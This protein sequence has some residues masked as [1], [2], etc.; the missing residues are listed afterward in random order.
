MVLS[1]THD[2]KDASVMAVVEAN[3]PDTPRRLRMLHVPFLRYRDG[4]LESHSLILTLKKR[5]TKVSMLFFC[6]M[7]II[8]TWPAVAC[9]FNALTSTAD[10]DSLVMFMSAEYKL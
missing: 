3:A 9:E 10:K 2:I 8:G 5:E 7:T 6:A 4:V 1:A